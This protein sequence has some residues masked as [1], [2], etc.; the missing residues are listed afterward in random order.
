MEERHIYT[1]YDTILN[2]IDSYIIASS[3]ESAIIK[4]D[5]F[6]NTQRVNI[7]FQK[8]ES[9]DMVWARE[10]TSGSTYIITIVFHDAVT[11][12]LDSQR[13]LISA[14]DFPQA[15]NTLRNQVGDNFVKIES[16]DRVPQ[17]IIN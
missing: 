10:N 17:I 11:H 6:T 5:N 1:A 7:T 3:Y 16:V 13:Y 9:S 15:I 8:I 12:T 4:Y 14:I 2:Q